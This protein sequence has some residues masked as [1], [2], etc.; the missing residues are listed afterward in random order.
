MHVVFYDQ[1]NN[2]IGTN[3]A[4]YLPDKL[5]TYSGSTWTA[6]A[7]E[8]HEVYRIQVPDNAK[9]FQINNGINKGLDANEE[10]THLTERYSVIEQIADNGLYKFVENAATASKYIKPGDTLPA[11]AA[12][13]YKPKYKLELLNPF[14]SGEETEPITINDVWLATVETDDTDGNKGKIKYIKDLKAEGVDGGVVANTT[15]VDRE[16]LDH[17]RNDIGETAGK[18]KV[19]VLQKGTYY[20]KEQSAPSGYKLNTDTFEFVY[21]DD[22]KIYARNE[23][24]FLVDVT[25]VSPTVV[26]KNEE[27]D[28]PKGEVILTKTAKE[29]VGTTDI[30][31]VLAGAQFKLVN[32]N[33]PTTEIKLKKTTPDPEGAVTGKTTNEYRVDN[34]GTYNTGTSYPATGEDG[35]LHIKGL[36]VGDYYLEE[37]KAP[38][39]YSEKELTGEKR[40]VYFSVGE[41]REVKQ[42]YASDETAPAY[43]KLYEHI[44]EKR[45]EWGNPTFVFKI[46]QT[47]YYDYSGETSAITTTDSGKEILVALTVDDDGKIVDT[48]KWFHPDGITFSADAIDNTT[49]GDWLVEGTTELDDY[50]GMFNIDSKGRIRVEPG[51]YEI[52]R[53][54][55]SRYEFVTNGN[56]DAYT[57]DTEPPVWTEY[58]VNGEKSEKLTISALPQ[59]KTIDV[60]YYDKV[61]YYDKFTQVNEE[62]NKFYTLDNKQNT[63]VKGI[64]IADYH[65]TGNVTDGDTDASDVMTVRVADLT[66]CK[67]MSDGTEAAMSA[68]EKNA[69]TGTNFTVSYTAQE[70]NSAAFA[71]ASTGF[72]YDN[73]AEDENN[74]ETYPQIVIKNASDYQKGVY[75]LKADY[76]G[77]KTSFDIVFLTEPTP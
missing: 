64:R 15:H 34:S 56:T 18:K 55:V 67:I 71:A 25:N 72:S 51:S 47:G 41:N 61:A 23:E 29:K 59:G 65:Q 22:G 50:Q 26:I 58:T 9:Y 70:G 28:T 24:G 37:Q 13:R 39:G 30:G 33:D 68:A 44:S 43:I 6:E 5:G 66:I 38:A 77:F 62:I 52:T 40:K 48:V 74:P 21:D 2:A 45:D 32:V 35:R 17:T 31:D 73:S 16:Y 57:N 8:G 20:W 42:I 49:Y 36:P 69:L 75:T 3:P 76:N 11:T 12:D 27:E 60:H 4:G 46:K 7:Y 53:L 54:P 19:K 10:D 1:N 63:A 14:T